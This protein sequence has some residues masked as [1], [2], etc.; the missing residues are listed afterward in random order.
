LNIVDEQ[1]PCKVEGENDKTYLSVIMP[2]K[3]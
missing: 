3:I 1:K 2:M